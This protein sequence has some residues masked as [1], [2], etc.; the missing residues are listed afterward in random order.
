MNAYKKA[1]KF[2]VDNIGAENNL[3]E[4]LKSVLENA[5]ETIEKLK[6]PRHKK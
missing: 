1:V 4:N 3:V 6:K 5:K 2:G